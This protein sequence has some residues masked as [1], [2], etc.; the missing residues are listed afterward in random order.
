MVVLLRSAISDKTLFTGHWRTTGM[1]TTVAW[2]ALVTVKQGIH[3]PYGIYCHS[4]GTERD[5]QHVSTGLWLFAVASVVGDCQVRVTVSGEGHG[6][7]YH[8]NVLFSLPGCHPHQEPTTP[9]SNGNVHVV[10][11]YSLWTQNMSI[12]GVLNSRTLDCTPWS[13]REESV[14]VGRFI[15]DVR[16][17]PKLPTTC[18]SPT[19]YNVCWLFE[20][21][22][23]ATGHWLGMSILLTRHVN[24]A[25]WTCQFRWLDMSIPLAGHVNTADWTC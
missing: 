18:N 23:A 7:R 11:K 22:T 15:T 6:V 21:V 25:D 8:N 4:V 16:M 9:V 12:A 5:K 17:S 13:K 24:S 10:Y 1:P 19:Q 14:R 20:Q 2:L 3:V